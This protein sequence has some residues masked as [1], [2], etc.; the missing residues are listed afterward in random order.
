MTYTS[1]S[2]R[3]D[4]KNDRIYMEKDLWKSCVCILLNKNVNEMWI[5]VMNEFGREQKR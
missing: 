3:L 2:Q 5:F 1:S 4:S